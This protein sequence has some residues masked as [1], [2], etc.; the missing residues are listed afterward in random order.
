MMRATPRA[1]SVVVGCK[2]RRFI[3][4]KRISPSFRLA[5]PPHPSHCHTLPPRHDLDRKVLSSAE[6]I[7]HRK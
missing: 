1:I 5:L 3:E 4:E 6:N 2:R 7:S